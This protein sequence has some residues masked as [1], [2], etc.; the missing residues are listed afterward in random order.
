MES[1][2]SVVGTLKQDLC[3]EG[4]EDADRELRDPGI[5]SVQVQ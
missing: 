4:T 1:P 2:G 3:L 5:L